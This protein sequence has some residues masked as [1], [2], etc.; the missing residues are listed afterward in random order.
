MMIK[1]LSL[2]SEAYGPMR[3]DL[4]RGATTLIDE[5]GVHIFSPRTVALIITTQNF[6]FLCDFRVK[7]FKFT[8]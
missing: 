3:V 8:S 4:P 7:N 6:G 2:A 1:V 5:S